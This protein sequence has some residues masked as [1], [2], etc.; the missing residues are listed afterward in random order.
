MILQYLPL[1]DLEA[2][3]RFAFLPILVDAEKR[4][5]PSEAWSEGMLRDTLESPA[6]RVWIAHDRQPSNI[7]AYGMLYLAGTE[8]DVANI[9]VLPEYRRAGVGAALLTQMMEYARSTGVQQLFLE[10]RVSNAPAI[11]LYRSHGFFEIGKRRNY[12]RH[13]Q[14]DALL[15]MCDLLISE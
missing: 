3:E 2:V 5:F 8:A 10:V 15:M 14:E 13:P 9:A 1:F 12:Y 6:S 4:C 7:V 11:G